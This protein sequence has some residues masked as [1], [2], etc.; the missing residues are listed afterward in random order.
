VAD[1]LLRGESTPSRLRW[2]IALSALVGVLAAV[3]VWQGNPGNMGICGA[4]F[5]RDLAGALGAQGSK[6]AIFRPEVAG[7]VLGPFA[8]VVLRGRFEARS[9]SHA[10]S[11]FVL[12]IWMGVGALVFLG[13]P[14]RLLQRLGGGDGTA[15]AGAAGLLAGVGLGTL[16]ERRGYSVGKTAPAPAAVGLLGPVLVLGLLALFLAE[17]LPRGAGE[18]VPH[19][20]W[21]IA[22]AIALV[23]GAAL[24]ATGFCAISACRQVFQPGK[25]MLIA[26]LA[27]IAGYAVFSLATGKFKAGFEGQPVAHGDFVA[28]FFALALVGLAGVFAGGCPV[29]Q[30]VMAGEG[31]GDALVTAAGIAVGGAVAHNMGLVSTAEGATP[32]GRVALGVGLVFVLAYAAAV[33]RAGRR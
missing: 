33:T 11:R 7:L 17:K 1:P 16:F 12:G 3:L 23:A 22:L 19:A 2:G 6:A 18:G 5:L 26:A 20:P 24:S 21:G 8:W 25:G 32:A 27:L 4:C 30:M 28:S 15:L 31:N 14:F 10:A 29:R 9:G 13:C